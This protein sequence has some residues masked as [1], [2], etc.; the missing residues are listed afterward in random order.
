MFS[1]H[2]LEDLDKVR[3]DGDRSVVYCRSVLFPFLKSGV[4]YC[5]FRSGGILPVSKE[6]FHS[7]Q[8][9]TAIV[10]LQLHRILAGIS[11]SSVAEYGFTD[12]FNYVSDTEL[13][14][15]QFCIFNWLDNVQTFFYVSLVRVTKHTD[16]LTLKNFRLPLLM[17]FGNCTNITRQIRYNIK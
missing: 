16:I 7:N 10:F 8:S 5:I 4:M 6:D 13:N 15:S 11:P 14:I 9:G 12:C 2:S 17:I 3:C 1:H